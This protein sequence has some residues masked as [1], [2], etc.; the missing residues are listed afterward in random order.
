VIIRI[1]GILAALGLMAG[2][3]AGAFAQT[4][5]S[6]M[7]APVVKKLKVRY[8][9][10]GLKVV[11]YYDFVKNHVSFIYGDHHYQ[12]P[13]V[14]AT[15]GLR[16]VGKGLEWW[17]KGSNVTLSSVDAGQTTGDTVLANCTAT[18]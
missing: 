13:K 4:A 5:P 17:E 1:S 8:D 14:V 16:Y 7:G 6:H 2:L 9:C 12:L 18:K 3:T 10:S 11:A 15:A